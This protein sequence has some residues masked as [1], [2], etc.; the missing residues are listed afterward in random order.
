M[1]AIYTM[2]L[3]AALALFMGSSTKAETMLAPADKD[4]ILTAAQCGMTEVKLGELASQKGMR[5]DVKAFGQKMVKDHTA[6]NAEL[7]TLAMQKGVT[8]PAN[9]D[10]KHQEM[11]DKLMAL[12]GEKF[13]EAYLADLHKG[14]KKDAKDFKTEAEDTKDPDI[15]SF[16]GKYL[17]VVNE[18]L[19]HINAMKK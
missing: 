9:L 1:K 5:D 16:V 4:F 17:P 19:E 14:H 11:V 13:D 12:T 8:L 7:T 15:K 10:A 2:A 6:M 3:V 18:H